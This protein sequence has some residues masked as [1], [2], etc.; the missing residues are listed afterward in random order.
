MTL[1]STL[2]KL[3]H[4][5]QVA[6]LKIR[7]PVTLLGIIV[8][9]WTKIL[10][11]VLHSVELADHGSFEKF[12]GK[13]RGREKAKQQQDVEKAAQISQV[14]QQVVTDALVDPCLILGAKEH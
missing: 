1:P 8:I 10:I 14:R 4:L 11:I 7:C 13:A 9:K 5:R 2:S 6:A 3:F 12:T